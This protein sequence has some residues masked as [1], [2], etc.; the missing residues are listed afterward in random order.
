M[1]GILV[2]AGSDPSGGAGIQA[3]IKTITSLN[4]YAA[5]AITTITCQNSMG[6]SRLLPLEPDLVHDQIRAVLSDMDISHIKIGMTGTTGII[7]AIISSLQSF[8]GELIVDPVLKSSTGTALLAGHAID[9]SPLIAKATVLTP[10]SGE[11]SQLT[12]LCCTTSATSIKAG[13]QLFKQFP[14]LQAICLKAGHLH[15]D[16]SQITDILLCNEAGEMR[17]MSQTHTRHQTQNSHGT[18]CTFA[19]AFSAFHAK[20]NTYDTAFSRTVEYMDRLLGKSKNHHLCQGIGP[21]IHFQQNGE[22]A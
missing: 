17:K 5:A 12:G 7:K 2:I 21:L 3:D 14:R 15:E 18:G 6:V 20:T 19:S 10:N 22:T 13:K 11:L 8:Q 16:R 9:I 4:M 1:R